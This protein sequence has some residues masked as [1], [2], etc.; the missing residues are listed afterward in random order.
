[1]TPST[2]IRLQFLIA[3][4]QLQP[5]E[6]VEADFKLPSDQFARLN[7]LNDRAREGKIYVHK[8]MATEEHEDG[9]GMKGAMQSAMFDIDKSNGKQEL[10][11]LMDAIRETTVEKLYEARS[12]SKIIA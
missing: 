7:H 12:D 6:L 9:T 8:A 11:E 4:V 1:M 10:K 2:N 3:T 5:T